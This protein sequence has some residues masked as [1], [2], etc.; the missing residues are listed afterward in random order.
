[1]PTTG[2]IYKITSQLT[3]RIYIGSTTETLLQRLA[4]H[5]S[6]YKSVQAGKPDCC[7][8]VRELIDL[9]EIAIE[10]LEEIEFTLK[11]ELFI[12]KMV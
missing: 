12:K 3:D 10:L 7:S 4:R 6:R 2:R 8:T 9:G 5:K 1:M 11:K